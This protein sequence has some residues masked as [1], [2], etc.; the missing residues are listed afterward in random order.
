MSI[1][2]NVV[3]NIFYSAAVRAEMQLTNLL[4]NSSADSI[5]LKILIILYVDKLFGKQ[6]TFK[7]KNLNV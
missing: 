2:I 3:K 1:E 4:L 7:E 6:K 5:K